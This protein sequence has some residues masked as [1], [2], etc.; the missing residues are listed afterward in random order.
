MK[1]L[2]SKLHKDRGAVA[3]WEP[4]QKKI[5]GVNKSCSISFYKLQLLAIKK[6]KF[7][8]LAFVLF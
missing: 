6:D 5:A 7:N 3:I 4:G 1:I 2:E 8:M